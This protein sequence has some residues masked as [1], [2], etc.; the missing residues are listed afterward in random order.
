M[1]WGHQGAKI[2]I[3]H[4]PSLV[5]LSKFRIVKSTGVRDYVVAPKTAQRLPR[6]IINSARSMLHVLR[7]KKA[8][9]ANVKPLSTVSSE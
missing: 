9:C 2:S 5:R 7:Y 4:A 8:S 3:N 6:N 1:Q